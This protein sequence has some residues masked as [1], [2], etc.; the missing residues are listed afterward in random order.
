[1]IGYRERSCAVGV[2]DG[3]IVGNTSGISSEPLYVFV[4]SGVTTWFG[5]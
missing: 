1:M 2:T 5:D 4:D 3:F